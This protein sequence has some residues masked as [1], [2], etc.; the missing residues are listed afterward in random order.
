MDWYR[1]PEGATAPAGTRTPTEGELGTARLDLP[2]V[3]QLK[4]AARRRIE[5]QAGDL[6]DIVA[7]QARQIEALMALTVRLGQV[8]LG[9]EQLD[10]DVQQRY[11]DRITPLAHALDDGALTL[12]GDLEDPDDMLARMQ[13]RA[14]RIN[15]IIAEEYLPRRNDL[16]S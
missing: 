4:A 8:V 1:I 16:M 5:A 12:R 11:L 9:G 2:P 7:D 14:D 10:S 6:H 15:D 13:A 3:R